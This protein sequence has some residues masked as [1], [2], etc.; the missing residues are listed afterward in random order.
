MSVQTYPQ[1]SGTY[2]TT[3]GTLGNNLT[4]DITAAHLRESLLDTWDSWVA[5]DATLSGRIVIASGVGA[6][7]TLNIST[8]S[9]VA[10]TNTLNIATVSGVASSGIFTG[11][12]SASGLVLPETSGIGIKLGIASPAFGYRDLIGY[13]VPR[14]GAGAGPAPTLS[15]YRGANILTYAFDA[16][17]VIDSLTFHMP[18]D[19]L[20]NSDMFIHTHWGHNG[21]TI[22][23]VFAVNYY[24][25][26]CKGYN[27][28]GQVFNSQVTVSGVNSA[29]NSTGVYPRWGHFIDE[30][31]FTSATGTVNTLDRRLLEIDGLINVGYKV[32]TKPTI[33]GGTVPSPFVFM[34]DIHYQT[35][36]INSTINKNFPFYS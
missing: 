24:I 28:A 17:D 35:T 27:Q 5:N 16:D 14:T 13:I 18:H 12:I 2:L 1:F 6:T 32:I 31:Q 33:T 25:E 29:V 36:G 9:G 15:A 23:G 30:V 3:S 21:T 26:Y 11:Q 34:I 20:P 22:T 4:G 19:Y 8:V 10:A 7:N